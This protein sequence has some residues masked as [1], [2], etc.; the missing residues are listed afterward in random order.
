[1]E[2]FNA[3]VDQKWMKD[4]QAHKLVN[5]ISSISLVTVGKS[6]FALSPDPKD[7]YLFDLS[8]QNN[9]VFLITDDT[10]LLCLSLKPVHV[11]STNWFLKQ[12]PA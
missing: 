11:H 10:E 3:V 7:N 1:M 2:V 12:F 8:I 5:F 4:H 6:V 9:C